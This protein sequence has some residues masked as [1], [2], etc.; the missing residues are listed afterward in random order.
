MRKNTVRDAIAAPA[1][2]PFPSP[3][4]VNFRSRNIFNG[5]FRV[6]VNEKIPALNLI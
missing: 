2:Q 3:T 6:P 5:L 1:P 4:S